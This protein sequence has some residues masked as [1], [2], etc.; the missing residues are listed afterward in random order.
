MG[1]WRA[2]LRLSL[3]FL[4]ARHVPLPLLSPVNPLVVGSIPTQGAI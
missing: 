1:F 3:C 4:T 2:T